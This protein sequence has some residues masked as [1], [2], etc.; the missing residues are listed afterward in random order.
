MN[1]RLRTRRRKQTVHLKPS[2]CERLSAVLLALLAL[3]KRHGSFGVDLRRFLSH[4]DFLDKHVKHPS[5]AGG[6]NPVTFRSAKQ[7]Y[8]SCHSEDVTP[9]KKTLPVDFLVLFEPISTIV[10]I[11]CFSSVEGKAA[12]LEMFSVKSAKGMTRLPTIQFG[13]LC[14]CPR[15]SQ[16][17][18]TQTVINITSRIHLKGKKAAINTQP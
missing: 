3:V 11:S 12:C 1:V 17:K 16:R 10:I 2:K 8:N 9:S 15:E 5:F 6:Y 7:L 14:Q 13:W 4:F 18:R